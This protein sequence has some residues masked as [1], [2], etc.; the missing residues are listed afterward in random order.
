MKKLRF[1]SPHL[2]R[3]EDTRSTFDSGTRWV[4]N[5]LPP[6]VTVEW[7]CPCKADILVTGSSAARCISAVCRIGG[8][9]RL[10]LVR[11]ITIS[12]TKIIT[13]TFSTNSHP[14]IT[15]GNACQLVFSLA[16]LESFTI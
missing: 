13:S 3:L 4:G 6:I 14:P 15:G 8:L 16:T 5:I 7:I 1:W 12:A 9:L 10:Y 2:A 11:Y